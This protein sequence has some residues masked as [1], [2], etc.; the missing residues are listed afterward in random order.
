MTANAL[1]NHSP[2]TDIGIGPIRNKTIIICPT[3]Q[4]EGEI[5]VH[6]DNPAYNGPW[7]KTCYTCNGAGRLV[8]I[9]TKEYLMLIVNRD[10]NKHY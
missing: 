3:C 8:Q 10:G 9:T 4:G 1:N 7:V 2:L 5:Q 6:N